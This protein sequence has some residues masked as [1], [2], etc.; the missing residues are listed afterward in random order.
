MTE[1][2]SPGLFRLAAR[3]R[4]PPTWTFPTACAPPS[5]LPVPP[6]ALDGSSRL[7][8]FNSG[9]HRR[10]S[11][12]RFKIS[13]QTA[14]PTVSF[15]KMKTTGESIAESL[16]YS[17]WKKVWSMATV[18]FF[19][20]GGLLLVQLDQKY[21]FK[22]AKY[23]GGSAILFGAFAGFIAVPMILDK[24]Q[25]NKAM[26]FRLATAHTFYSYI[27]FASFLPIVG[28]HFGRLLESRKAISFRQNDP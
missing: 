24:M 19:C 2:V 1:I 16:S 6:A 27:M 28:P 13:T 21:K 12:N 9:S 26:S 15:G 7:F 4:E 18:I 8:R 25:E 11:L 20:G 17:I 23:A 22:P 5:P 14:F 10:S 3:A